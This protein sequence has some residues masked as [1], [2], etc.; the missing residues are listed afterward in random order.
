MKTKLWL[1]LVAVALVV[2]ACAA[3]PNVVSHVDGQ[4]L[5]GFWKGLWHGLIY[6]V[7]FI[8]SLFT[9]RVSIYEV[10]NN[11]NWYDF[12]FVAGIGLLHM[13]FGGH[14]RLTKRRR[15]PSTAS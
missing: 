2:T 8:I 4:Q 11:G 6:P 10:H 12:G 14:R 13:I 1:L 9:D 3:G 15:E 7:T 5:A